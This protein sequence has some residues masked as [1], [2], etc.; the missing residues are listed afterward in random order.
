MSRLETQALKL[1]LRCRMFKH[2]LALPEAG[3]V[4]DQTEIIVQILEVMNSRFKQYE[5]E[6]QEHALSRIQR[7]IRVRDEVGAGTRRRH[8]GQ[9]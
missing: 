6:E 3:G 1:F 9:A 2:D 7:V 5:A 4:T 8:G